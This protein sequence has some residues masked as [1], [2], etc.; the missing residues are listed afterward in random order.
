[1]KQLRSFGQVFLTDA[2]YIQKI[3]NSLDIK[4][5]QVLEIGPGRGAMSGL[6]AEKAK[7]L[8]CVEVDRRFCDFLRRKFFKKDNVEIIHADILKFSLSKL[9]NKI[10]IFGNI[11]YQISSKLIKYLIDYRRYIEAAYLTFQKEFVQKMT[12]APSCDN[13]NFLSCYVQYYAKVERIFDIKASAFDPIP[14]VDSTFS[15]INFYGKSPYKV[16]NEDFL[17]KVIRK[18]FSSRRKKVI[19]A[20]NLSKNNRSFFESTGLNLS[21]RPENLSLKDYVS[22]ANQ[23]YPVRDS[24]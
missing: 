1:M 11:P 21:L 6:L 3:F 4:G 7:K 18:A 24:N 22:V 20:L 5:K 17:F 10:I 2:E 8:Y 13:Y 23:L 9:G 12:A 14:K 16:K 19:N 15:K